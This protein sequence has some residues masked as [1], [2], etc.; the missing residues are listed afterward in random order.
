MHQEN[1]YA[2]ESYSAIQK[3]PFGIG[4]FMLPVCKKII[5]VLLGALQ[6]DSRQPWENVKDCSLGKQDLE[7]FSPSSLLHCVSPRH[8]IVSHS[9]CLENGTPNGL[10][11]ILFTQPLGIGRD[12]VNFWAKIKNNVFKVQKLFTAFS[13]VN[14]VTLMPF[15]FGNLSVGILYQWDALLLEFDSWI[16]SFCA[17]F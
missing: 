7:A 8:C 9:I 17:R 16:T 3:K 14:A 4:F 2:A 6:V 13:S 11:L 10:S 12:W 15:N 5:R 1:L